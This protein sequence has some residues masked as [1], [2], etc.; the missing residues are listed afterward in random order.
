[1]RVF[2]D[3]HQ[4]VFDQR[5]AAHPNV[6]RRANLPERVVIEFD[7]E[8]FELGSRTIQG[9]RSASAGTRST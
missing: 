7:R 8:H 1:V 3:R 2:L 5:F 4:A 6:R 9:C